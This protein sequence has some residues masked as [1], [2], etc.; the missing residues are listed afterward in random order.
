M[1]VVGHMPAR[2]T[3]Y[4]SAYGQSRTWNVNPTSV[5]QY[6]FEVDGIA[7]NKWTEWYVNGVY[8]GS[9]ENDYSGFFAID[10]NYTYTFSSGATQIKALVYNNDFTVLHETHTWNVTVQTVISAYW[11]PPLFVTEGA[12]AIMRAEV[13]GFAIG[14]Q[15]SLEI[16]EDDSPFG[17]DPVT[18][19]T[20]NVY[21][22][23]GRYYVDASWTTVWQSDQ[24]G[25][26]EFYFIVSRGNV[27]R[28]SSRADADELHVANG[29]VLARSPSSLSGSVTQ[30]QNATSQSFEVWN[31]GGAT[32]SY[33]ISD[34]A[35]WLS[36]SPSS[37]TSTGEHDTLTVSYSTTSLLAGTYN[38]TINISA[39]GAT[40]SPQTITVT[41]TV[42][43]PPQ[44]I[45]SAYWLA[46]NYVTEGAVATVRA[47]VSGFSVGDQFAFEI[48]EDD[49]PFGSYYVTTKYGNVYSSGGNLYADATWTTVWQSDQSG[50]PEFYC[51]VSRGSVSKESSRADADEMHV[52]QVDPDDQ[53]SEAHVLGS[54]KQTRVWTGESISPSTDVDM[55]QFTAEAEQRISFDVDRPAGSILDAYIRLFD[56][57]GTQLAS[58]DNAAGP[59]E[60][61]STE[62][63]L[64]YTFNTSGTYYIDS[65]P[66]ADEASMAGPRRR[67]GPDKT[68][69]I[70]PG[71]ENRVVMLGSRY[72]FLALD[73]AVAGGL[74]SLTR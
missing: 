3:T 56:S 52:T 11:L 53:I 10:P 45:I 13:G 73:L 5:G 9:A 6:S 37:G 31:S 19:K 58:N 39:S 7:Q 55:Y 67:I 32:L 59:G 50:D 15:F 51:I 66:W 30:G 40:G 8:A 46:P 57:A 74:L 35:S 38:A 18:T 44:T 29:P 60:P 21:S 17:S 42:N 48:R 43:P 2:A 65:V 1:L 27:L 49:S 24:I 23:G 28:E 26:P 68:V 64:Q 54:M 16:R 63:Y 22:S 20:G 70:S 61:S 34:N 4:Y 47:Q 14:D 36:V 33:S 69:G 12:V 71:A 72:G 41:L 62:P 25:D